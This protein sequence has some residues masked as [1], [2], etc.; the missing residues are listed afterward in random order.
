MGELG[1]HD[2]PSSPST[3]EDALTN[4]TK[5]SNGTVATPTTA[6]TSR[7]IKRQRSS[8]LADD[9]D[10]DD[11]KPGRERRKIEIKFIQDKSRRHITFSKRKAG[12]MKKV[13]LGSLLP[14]TE[15]LSPYL[16]MHPVRA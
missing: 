6:E 8:T 1:E 11:D 16:R 12:I 5:A 14:P 15:M 10:D 4:A 3:H 7:G 13:P 9:D 2:R